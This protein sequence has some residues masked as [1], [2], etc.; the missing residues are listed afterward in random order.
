[1]AGLI[2]T[3][4]VRG[5]DNSH[6]QNHCIRQGRIAR[7]SSLEKPPTS[8]VRLSNRPNGASRGPDGPRTITSGA[9]L[10]VD[11]CVPL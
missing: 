7:R 8:S 9:Q 10:G 4:Q 6:R 5:G 2:P 1:M 11:L 3:L